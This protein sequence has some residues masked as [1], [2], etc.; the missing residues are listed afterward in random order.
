MRNVTAAIGLPVILLAAVT[1]TGC[2]ELGI[3]GEDWTE[4]AA[5]PHARWSQIG[6][7]DLGAA[8]IRDT[9]CG[10][11]HQIPGIRTAD[12]LVGPPLTHMAR[13]V[14]I[15]GVLP[16]TPENMLGWLQDPQAIVPGNAMPDVGLSDEDARHVA[17]YLYTLD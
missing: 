11:C 14:Y 3:G 5:D 4:Q 17:A 1:L 10:T 7:P 16:N 6:D 13:R 2:D 12:G 9:G 15:A 8:L